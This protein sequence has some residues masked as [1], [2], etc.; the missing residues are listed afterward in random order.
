M[1]KAGQNI[2]RGVNRSLLC[3][4]SLEEFNIMRN[5]WKHTGLQGSF[6]ALVNRLELAPVPEERILWVC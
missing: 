6:G 3:S 5:V 2:Q 4:D 1:R